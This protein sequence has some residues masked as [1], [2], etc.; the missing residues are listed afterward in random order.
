MDIHSEFWRTGCGINVDREFMNTLNKLLDM[1][2]TPKKNTHAYMSFEERKN[3]LANYADEAA[4]IAR[5]Y[6]GQEDGVLFD[7]TL[8][9]EMV[10]LDSPTTDDLVASFLPIFVY[11]THEIDALK[12]NQKL[13]KELIIEQKKQI[14]DLQKTSNIDNTK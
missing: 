6:L 14:N 4:A 12:E 3:L 13:L 9:E 11:L 8:P 2:K 7:D 5:E 10:S 1:E